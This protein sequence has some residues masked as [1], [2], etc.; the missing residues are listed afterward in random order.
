L[1]LY[2]I[3]LSNFR[4]YTTETIKFGAKLNL[5]GGLNGSGKTNLLDA[6][7]YLSF[8]KS[9][10]TATD[11]S[12][13]RYGE[14]FLRIEGNY[15][16]SPGDS[17]VVKLGKGRKKQVEWNRNTCESLAEHVGRIPLMMVAPDD[18]ELVK[19]ASEGRRKLLNMALSQLNRDYLQA[20][21]CYNKVL[22]QRNALLKQYE[23]PK[24]PDE[25]LMLGYDLALSKEAKVI[26][27]ERNELC[28]QIEPFFLQYHQR[29]TGGA[30]T[31][32]M[33]YKSSLADESLELSLKNARKKE[34]YLQ[35]TTA[36][37][38]KD[39]LQFTIAEHALKRSGSQGQQ[40]SFLLALKLAL[41]HWIQE[42]MDKQPILL[43][44]DLFDKLDEERVGRL[45]ELV[46]GDDFGQVFITDTQT[47]RLKVLG[48][49]VNLK[50]KLLNI[51]E[52]KCE[53]FD[54]GT[55]KP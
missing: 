10:F 32:E 29:I 39:E 27:Q 33:K 25:E 51:Q 16:E 30:E 31:V 38:H 55:L 1:R 9:Y 46:S 14:T 17:V 2:Q 11:S 12:N 49:A 18:S 24:M 42:K 48:D 3:Q 44:D 4:N 53:S 26:H 50:Y 34:M 6:I 54:R 22:K 7:H 15:G 5:I 19:G 41:L 35:R 52:G 37:I 8:G 23:Y 21:L 47:A 40:K 36:G 20:L 43:L 13:I 45:L 28:I